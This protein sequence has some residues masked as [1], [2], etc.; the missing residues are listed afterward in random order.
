[1]NLWAYEYR[2]HEQGYSLIAGVD[3]AGRGPLA[4]PVVSAAV[5]LPDGFSPTKVADSKMLTPRQRNLLFEEIR[6]HAIAVGVGRVAPEEID[7]I[8]ILQAALRS[9]AKAVERLTPQ[10][11]YLL[12][13]GKFTIPSRLPQS[14]IVKGDTLSISIAVASVVAKVTRDRIM[15]E[16]HNTYPQYG[17]AAHKGYPTLAHRAAIREFG[18]CPIHRRTF[19]GVREYVG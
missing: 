8:N 6:K 17:F 14:P 1:M 2:T 9:M 19:K 12:I 18:P 3:E 11:D 10:P 7:R 15:T 5:I 16:Y 4:G 13:D